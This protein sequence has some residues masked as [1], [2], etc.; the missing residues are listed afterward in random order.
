MIDVR[1]VSKFTSL[2]G[3][4]NEDLALLRHWLEDLNPNIHLPLNGPNNLIFHNNNHK[5][6]QSLCMLV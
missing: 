3:A 1:L 6:N 4:Q 2:E 5:M